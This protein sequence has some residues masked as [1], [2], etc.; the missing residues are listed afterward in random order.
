VWE[1]DEVPLAEDFGQK[2]FYRFK[3][4]Q[5]FSPTYFKFLKMQLKKRPIPFNGT[6]LPWNYV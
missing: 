3:Q 4:M 6:T 1:L 2:Q 5:D